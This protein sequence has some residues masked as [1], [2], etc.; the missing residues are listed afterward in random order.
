MENQEK[1]KKKRGRP[2]NSG[3]PTEK[4]KQYAELTVGLNMPK[5]KAVLEVYDTTPKN[6]P[7]M[8]SYIENTPGT[9]LALEQVRQKTKDKIINTSDEAFQILKEIMADPNADPK[10]R[11]KVA[12]DFLDRASIVDESNNKSAEKLNMFENVFGDQLKKIKEIIGEENE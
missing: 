12:Q 3:L 10:L 6:A 5:T 2:V 8:V 1:P 7:A 4:Q 9:K 11:V